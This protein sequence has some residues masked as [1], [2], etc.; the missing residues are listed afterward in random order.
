MSTKYD[1]DD[2]IAT[3]VTG[4]TLYNNNIHIL[5]NWSGK[6]IYG[7]I[8][9]RVKKIKYFVQSAVDMLKKKR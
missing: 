5:H 3:L 8:G 1:A 4:I 6:Y 2:D 9:C 7:T